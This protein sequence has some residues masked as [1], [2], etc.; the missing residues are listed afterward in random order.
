[1][2]SETKFRNLITARVKRSVINSYIRKPDVINK[3]LPHL[4][5]DN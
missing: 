5:K 3:Y 2:D 4:H 1:V